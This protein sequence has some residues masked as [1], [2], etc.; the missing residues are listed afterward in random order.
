MQYRQHAGSDAHR[1]DGTVWQFTPSLHSGDGRWCSGDVVIV[2]GELLTFSAQ[3][4][5]RS[6]FRSFVVQRCGQKRY[7]HYRWKVGAQLRIYQPASNGKVSR[8]Y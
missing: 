5:N 6:S 4:L 3:L 2:Y 1:G 8:F 7:Y